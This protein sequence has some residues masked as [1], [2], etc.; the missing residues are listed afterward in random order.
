MILRFIRNAHTS[1]NRTIANS[2]P[3][4]NPPP[5]QK[6]M[7]V[8]AQ[9]YEQVPVVLCNLLQWLK[10][11]DHLWLIRDTCT[12][13]RMNFGK[14]VWYARFLFFTTFNPPAVEDLLAFLS[15]IICSLWTVMWTKNKLTFFFQIFFFF[16]RKF[17]LQPL[18]KFSCFSVNL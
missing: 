2:F 11:L 10:E 3:N 14:T 7:C 18:S 8:G 12:S 5:P 16:W 15:R 13:C 4:F 1:S 17:L 6:G 9:S